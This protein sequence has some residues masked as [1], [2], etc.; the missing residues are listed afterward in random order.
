MFLSSLFT[1][2][3]ESLRNLRNTMTRLHFSTYMF[4]FKASMN[5]S[6]YTM[7]ILLYLGFAYMFIIHR[8]ITTKV[9]LSKQTYEDYIHFNNGPK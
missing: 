7:A 8:Y 1:E 3:A 6:L 2:S 4:N 9:E 5:T